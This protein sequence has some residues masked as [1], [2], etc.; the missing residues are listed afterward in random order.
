MSEKN[1]GLRTDL[2]ISRHVQKDGIHYVV[3]DPLAQEYYRFPEEEYSVITLFDGS[4]TLE[5]IV[6]KYNRNNPDSEIDL[7]LVKQFY[8]TLD[9]AHLLQKSLSAEDQKFSGL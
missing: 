5:K 1:P 9:K 4:N 6:Q 3:K 7:E 8:D 2:K